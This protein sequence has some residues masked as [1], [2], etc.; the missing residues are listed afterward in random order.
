MEPADDLGRFRRFTWWTL[1]GTN[2]LSLVGVVGGWLITTAAA[3]W[4]WVAG[5]VTSGV[6]AAAITLLFTHRLSLGSLTGAEVAPADMPVAAVAMGVVA[7]TALSSVMLTADGSRAWPLAPAI[8]A[9]IIVT[10][11]SPGRRWQFITLAM[12]G[13]A[14][15]G[16]VDATA[17]GDHTLWAVALPPVIVG[18]VIWITLGIL[19]SW[20]VAERLDTAGRLSADAAVKDERLRF[21]AELHDVQGHHLQVIALKSELAA[22]LVEADPQRAAA[23][24]REV[25]RLSVDALHDT[26]A[27]AYGY[28]DTTLG[29]EITNATRVLAAAGVETRTN[30]PS[31]L[32]DGADHLDTPDRQLL[33]LVVREATTNILRHSAA[34]S[35]EIG[36]ELSDG[37]L[38]L[39]IRND[40]ASSAAP[41]VDGSGLSSLAARVGARGGRLTWTNESERFTLTATLPLH[42]DSEAER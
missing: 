22:R 33:G 34:R 12:G 29:A 35:A 21:A 23:E 36:S 42:V 14:A 31:G 32:P 37:V 25:R 11:L 27:V 6:I 5:T 39:R 18:S 2:V 7:A 3:P 17:S 8:M 20:D 16:A 1:T 10:Y 41:A 38:C 9:S 4:V 28:R 26:R 15:I 30:P 19:W 24:M 13:A 40:G